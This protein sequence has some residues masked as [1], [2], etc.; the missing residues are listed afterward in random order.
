[1][2]AATLKEYVEKVSALID[3]HGFAIQYVGGDPIVGLPPT[4]Y[5]VGLADRHGYEL[6]MSGLR[7]EHIHHVLHELIERADAGDVVPREGLLVSGVLIDEYQLKLRQVSQPDELVIL[8]AFPTSAVSPIWQALFPDREG[9]FPGD[10]EYAHGEKAQR[11][12]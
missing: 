12:L 8:R 1:M 10:P 6:A 3:A 5:T 11:L 7:A 9:L 2:D 4:A